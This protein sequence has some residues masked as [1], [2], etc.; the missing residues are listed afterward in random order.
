MLLPPADW[1]TC[2]VSPCSL[3]STCSST[4][5]M[6]SMTKEW[7]VRTVAPLFPRLTLWELWGQ[8]PCTRPHVVTTKGESD[9]SITFGCK[10]SNLRL[11]NA[12]S[13]V[14]GPGNKFPGT[15][16][17][18]EPLQNSCTAAKEGSHTPQESA[19]CLTPLI[20]FSLFLPVRGQLDIHRH[21][22]STDLILHLK[23]MPGF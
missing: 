22:T 9:C 1:S 19:H 18:L 4:R 14:G 23:F 12:T 10:I 6:N 3:S 20:L 11:C 15:A 16:G 8:G 13:L 17:A 21:S 2:E 5:M 7:H